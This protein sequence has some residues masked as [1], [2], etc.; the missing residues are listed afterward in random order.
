MSNELTTTTDA[1]S[2]IFAEETKKDKRARL[3]IK[4]I[5]E[6]KFG[7]AS[8]QYRYSKKEIA[9]SILKS[10]GL[11]TNLTRSLGCSYS[12]IYRYFNNHPEMR[13]LWED[14]RREMVAK[15]EDVLVREL[16]SN[17]SNARL[18]AAKFILERIGGY[19]GR[20]TCQEITVNPQNNSVSIRQIFGLGE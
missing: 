8:L 16:A 1:Q 13:K 10:G 6:K 14:T 15:A 3:K 7:F 12:E 17:S 2:D 4:A 5:E 19:S 11:L 9:D 18:T 20:E